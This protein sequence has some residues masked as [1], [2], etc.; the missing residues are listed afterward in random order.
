M[1]QLAYYWRLRP[2]TFGYSN[3]DWPE[4]KIPF[5]IFTSQYGSSGKPQATDYAS[6]QPTT[7][8]EQ[9][10]I[11]FLPPVKS[12]QFIVINNFGST[13]G[14][15]PNPQR[16]TGCR[17]YRLSFSVTERTTNTSAAITGITFTGTGGSAKPTFPLSYSSAADLQTIFEDLFPVQNPTVAV[18][19]ISGL[20]FFTYNITIDFTLYGSNQPRPTLAV[21]WRPSNLDRIRTVDAVGT[22]QATIDF[23]EGVKPNGF[24]QLVVNDTRYF[25]E[26]IHTQALGISGDA[27]PFPHEVG[28]HV[29]QWSLKP[30]FY[31]LP[32]QTWDLQYTV[33]NDIP[34]LNDYINYLNT[35]P[36]P[37]E[38]PAEFGTFWTFAEVFCSYYLFEDAEAMICHQLLKLG[39]T[40][41][42]DSV[43]WYK[44]QILQSEG[45]DTDT[46]EVYLDLQKKWAEKQK[47]LEKHYHRGRP[48]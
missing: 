16:V 15:L 3:Q 47:R 4:P 8:W 14:V 39:I 37:P 30:N 1:R 13:P 21:N 29:P 17:T 46:F 12:N 33:M 38:P 44:K 5:S 24:V 18:T 28:F 7:L 19:K 9:K 43:I 40:I 32:G 20:D 2:E 27:A 23:I 22:C 48:K 11:A 31:V 45:L 35:A 34:A 26:P 6:A 41:N 42:P 25:K 36:V 10:Q